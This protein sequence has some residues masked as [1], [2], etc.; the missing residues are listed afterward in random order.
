MLRACSAQQSR[1]CAK[2]TCAFGDRCSVTVRRVPMLFARKYESTSRCSLKIVTVMSVAGSHAFL[3]TS[4]NGTV[5]QT[6]QSLAALEHLESPASH[7]LTLR[8]D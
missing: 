8:A 3:P 6:K 7:G 1:S 2:Y 4:R 5:P